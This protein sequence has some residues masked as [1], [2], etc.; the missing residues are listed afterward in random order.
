MS[1]FLENQINDTNIIIKRK[2][3][4]KQNNFRNNNNNITKN[5]FCRKGIMTSFRNFNDYNNNNFKESIS[6]N[7]YNLMKFNNAKNSSKNSGFESS[8]SP[9]VNMKYVNLKNLYN[10][11]ENSLLDNKFETIPIKNRV[12]RIKKNKIKKYLLSSKPKDIA[13]NNITKKSI[14]SF[15]DFF[16]DKKI[17]K[18]NF[19]KNNDEEISKLNLSDPNKNDFLKEKFGFYLYNNKYLNEHFS[20]LKILD[21]NKIMN[22]IK[23]KKLIT[24]NS[25]FFNKLKSELLEENK[26]MRK[27][28]KSS[29]STLKKRQNVFNLTKTK[30]N[31][32]K[33]FSKIFY[34]YNKKRGKKENILTNLYINES[35]N[36]KAKIYDFGEKKDNFNI[37]NEKNIVNLAQNKINKVYHD[38][39]IFDIPNL[40]DKFYIR[41]LLYDVFI[42]FKNMLLLSMMKNRDINLYKYGL[43]LDSFYNCNTKMNQQ[44]QSI[45][46]N[47]FKIFNKRLDNKYMTFENYINGMIK[48]K[49]EDKEKRLNLFFDMIDES[50]KG[51][52]S[53]DDIY[54]F[55]IISLQKI[56]M[57]IDTLEDFEKCKKNKK[58]SNIKILEGLADFFVRMIFKLVNIDIKENIPLNLLK[59]E[60]IKGGETADYIEFLF[61]IMNFT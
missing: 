40:N 21:K 55:G 32:P 19:F 17:I 43:D 10:S 16:K 42:E 13:E 7:S 36:P 44:G 31:T 37:I 18:D 50:S 35:K 1:S 20:T 34:S 47:L 3:F 58:N 29:Y 54:K 4:Y 30:I 26:K 56:T 52:M 38:L 6:N 9:I 23:K 33:E 41:K 11:P 15:N 2:S 22:K 5:N 60:I 39:L 57:N 59:K 46:E 8:K 51:Y 61:G 45:A 14:K 48:L 53:Y 28:I 49:N 12:N 27:N 25:S 24:D